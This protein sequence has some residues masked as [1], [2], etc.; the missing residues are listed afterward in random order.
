M[1]EVQAST[2]DDSS[3]EEEVST[4]YGKKKKKGV[5]GSVESVPVEKTQKGRNSSRLSNLIKGN[6]SGVVVS[7]GPNGGIVVRIRGTS[8]F[9][10]N[11]PLYVVD[12]T[13]VEADPGGALSWINPRDV[14][15]I[16]VLK[17]A[18]ASIYGSRGS[19]GVIVV[20]TN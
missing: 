7:D 6:V 10:N 12:G 19:N 17:G 11:D 13:P 3:R 20:E 8:S 16:T 14:K 2:T 4:G 5:S 18:S 15:S 1:A 9:G